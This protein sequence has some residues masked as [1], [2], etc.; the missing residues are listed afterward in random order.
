MIRSGSTLQYNL[1]RSLLEHGDAGCGEG[2]VPAEDFDVMRGC[3][4]R[5][6]NDEQMHVV[7]T[8][9][10]YKESAALVS[11]GSAKICYT[12]RDLRDV[13]SSIY[14]VW[15]HKGDDLIRILDD[16]V[17]T[18][19]SI[20]SLPQGVFYQKYEDLVRDIRSGASDT[21]DFL[22][23]SPADDVLDLV[24]IEC[25]KAA[26]I[27]KAARYQL[28]T[29]FRLKSAIRRTG[30]FRIIKRLPGKEVIPRS[31]LFYL[32]RL[33]HPYDQRTLLHVNHVSREAA[34]V[35]GFSEDELP[36][37]DSGIVS[38]RYKDWLKQKGYI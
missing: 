16:A 7:K 37:S 34:S 8:H 22:G 9:D 11:D 30:A 18:Y 15:R 19:Y 23:L 27:N 29:G 17:A 13:A 1:V 33:M 12:Y 5:W 14:R 35:S 38:E 31:A 36:K 2:Y 4:R 26:A 32:K 28:S 21:A 24:A 3:F 10:F 20:E 6:A 25:S